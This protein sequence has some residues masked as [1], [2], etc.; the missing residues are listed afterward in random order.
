MTYEPFLQGCWCGK[1]ARWHAAVLATKTRACA[2]KR[3]RLQHTRRECDFITYNYNKHINHYRGHCLKRKRHNLKCLMLLRRTQRLTTHLQLA[4]WI[5]INKTH[6][7][8]IHFHWTNLQVYAASLALSKHLSLDLS[9][10]LD[11]H[12]FLFLLQSFLNR[13]LVHGWSVI[14]ELLLASSWGVNKTRKSHG[15]VRALKIDRGGTMFFF[16]PP[17]RRNVDLKLVKINKSPLL[18][19]RRLQ[20]Q[21]QGAS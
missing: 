9:S 18:I 6:Q 16:F 7:S 20:S 11:F 8:E 12:H 5:S 19:T 2:E 4:V 13:C 10:S 3:L 14:K 17:F 1:Q 21:S 15:L